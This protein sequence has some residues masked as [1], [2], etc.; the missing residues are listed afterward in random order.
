VR[1]PLTSDGWREM[2]L[3]TVVLGAAFVGLAWLSPPLA[4]IPALIWIWAISFFRDPERPIPNEPGILVSPADGKVTHVLEL[5]HDDDI[6]GPALRV[7]IFLSVFNVHINRSPCAGRVRSIS[8]RKGQFINALSPDSSHRN[9]AN[10]LVLDGESGSPTT[11]VLRQIAG[12]IARRIVCHA[13]VGDRLSTGQ[14]FGMIKFGSRTEVTIPRNPGDRVVVQIG[15]TVNAGKTI[16]IR[17]AAG[18]SS[19]ES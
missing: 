17:L 19:K 18:A 15:Q 13:R 4:V 9:E 11:I 5:D 7:S 3:A 14:R 1:I 2:A 16:L 8:Y 6:G 10:T 12:L